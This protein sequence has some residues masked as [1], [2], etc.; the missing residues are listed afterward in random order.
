MNKRV[1]SLIMDELEVNKADRAKWRFLQLWT[2]KTTHPMILRGY[3]LQ[4]QRSV[5]PIIASYG[6][7]HLDWEYLEVKLHRNLLLSMGN[8]RLINN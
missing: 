8:M 7:E 5:Y 4:D 6:I 1:Y 3:E 2:L